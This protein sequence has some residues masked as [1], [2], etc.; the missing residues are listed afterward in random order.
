LQ[1]LSAEKRGRYLENAVGARFLEAGWD[2]YYWKD[3]DL[4]VDFVVL[5][6]G[7]E[8][9]AIEVKSAESPLD[10]L[11]GLKTFCGRYPDFEPCLLSLVGQR[12]AGCRALDPE[13]VLSLRRS[14]R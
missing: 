9:W 14:H 11:K 12:A 2:V 8:K 10:G 13:W 6:P 1:D 5:G 4:E 7:G 3:R